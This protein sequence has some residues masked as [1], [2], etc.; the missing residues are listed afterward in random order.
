M[1]E[2]KLLSAQEAI[3]AGYGSRAT[4]YRYRKA[5]KLPAVIK[6][7]RLYYKQSDLEKLT[8]PYTAEEEAVYEEYAKK[9]MADMPKFSLETKQ[10][11]ANLVSEYMTV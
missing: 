11:L 6:L 10:K 7:G 2:E 5:G 1:T 9:L 4:L 8:S 3:D